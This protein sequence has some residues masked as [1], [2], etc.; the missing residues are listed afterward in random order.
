[1]PISYPNDLPQIVITDVEAP[2]LLEIAE[3]TQTRAAQFLRAELRRATILAEKDLP[4]GA[5]RINSTVRFTIDGGPP[6]S[7]KL[8]YPEHADGRGNRLSILS[9]VGA[10]LLGL[11][12]GQ[13]MPLP[14]GDGNAWIRVLNV[15]DPR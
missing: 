10:A 5:A 14:T 7:A 3:G 1:M 11:A 13:M 4:S 6:R 8:V 2:K 12:R 9:T 15:S